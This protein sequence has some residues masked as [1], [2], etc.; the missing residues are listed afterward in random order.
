MN[1][2]LNF[3]MV[4]GSFVKGNESMGQS[5]LR[6]SNPQIIDHRSSIP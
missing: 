3:E 6:Q 4:I 1:D 5:S 2:E